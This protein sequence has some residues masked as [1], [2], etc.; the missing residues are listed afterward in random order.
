MAKRILQIF[1]V[2]GCLGLLGYAI[3]TLQ[4]GTGNREDLMVIIPADVH[5]LLHIQPGKSDNDGNVLLSLISDPNNTQAIKLI[6]DVANAAGSHETWKACADIAHTLVLFNDQNCRNPVIIVP[7]KR[8]TTAAELLTGF[9]QNCIKR[10]FEQVTIAHCDNTFAAVIVG[11]LILS[12]ASSVLEKLILD[13][14]HKKT[15]SGN[16]SQFV[17]EFLE[18]DRDFLIK[19]NSTQ[20]WIAEL[21]TSDNGLRTLFG[22]L[23]SDSIST[24][25]QPENPRPM[26]AFSIQLPPNL[27]SAEFLLTS[28]YKSTWSEL[29]TYYEMHNAKVASSW[30]SAW[31]ELADTSLSLFDWR[32]SLHGTFRLQKE[33]GVSSKISCIGGEDTVLITQR[34]SPLISK[35]LAEYPGVSKMYNHTLLERNF[36]EGA[37]G[38]YIAE[39]NHILYLG[40]SPTDLFT[41]LKDS[42]DM[43]SS[44]LHSWDEACDQ[45]FAWYYWSN[46]QVPARLKHFERYHFASNRVSAHMRLEDE[47]P[48]LKVFLHDHV[49][50]EAV[51]EDEKISSETNSCFDVTHHADGSKEKLCI[52]NGFAERF[53]QQSTSL[54]NVN[55]EGNVLGNVSE[56]D[57]L[58]NGKLQAAFTT[59]KKLYVIDRKGNALTGFPISVAN[60]ITS[61]LLV[62]DYNGDKKYR[63]IFG[64]SDGSIMNYDISGN[65]VPGWKFTLVQ[66]SVNAVLYLRCEG[67]DHLITIQEDGQIQVLKRNGESR[68]LRCNNAPSYDGKE[69][70]VVLK[71]SALSSAELHYTSS[72]GESQI[73]KLLLDN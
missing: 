60:S 9:G 39:R 55:V 68:N 19:L 27:A 38:S 16:E 5:T 20:W 17:K 63:L 37:D 73:I 18:G 2:T 29:N 47:K 12:S 49:V 67:E 71:G 23:Q 70:K 6:S 34:L 65:P 62:A 14:N 8:E 3:Y 46:K 45:A 59:N 61:G 51:S 26:G 7:L 31:S 69:C 64:T 28:D 43:E 24:Y 42:S 53:D 72:N 41:L 1:L 35:P 15:I 11:H 21:G 13:I 56:V 32:K 58:Q 66:P 44:I 54:F 25:Y 33:D 30:K 36:L 40:S 10:E 57:G 48:Y 4:K 22:E 50:S 52:Q